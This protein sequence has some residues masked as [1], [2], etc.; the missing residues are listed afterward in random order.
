MADA[1][2]PGFREVTKDEFFSVLGPLDVVLNLGDPSVTLWETRSRHVLGKTTPGWKF[3]GEEPHYY[4][5]DEKSV[6]R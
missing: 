1:R 3:P 4:L 5:R 2:F 6:S